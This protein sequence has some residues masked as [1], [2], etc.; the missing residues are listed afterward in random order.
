M[1]E[2]GEASLLLQSFVI[3]VKTQFERDVKIIRSDNELEFL[4][5]SMKQFYTQKGIIHHTSCIDTPQQN[6][7]VERKHRHVLNVAPPLLFQAYLTIDFWG[8]SILTATYVINRTPSKVLGGKTP[9]KVLFKAQ[10]PYDHVKMLGCLCYTHFKSRTRDKFA[11]RS[12]KCVFVGY[13]CGKKGWKVYDLETNEIFVSCDV[14]F[15]KTIFPF[16]IHKVGKNEEELRNANLPDETCLR[17]WSF[18]E[19]ASGEIEL[20][21]G[22]EA[23][24]EHEGASLLGSGPSAPAQT[25]GDAPAGSEGLI[26]LMG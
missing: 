26:S 3:M 21:E 1:R 25:D 4:S 23:T 11:P 8:E 12:R 2:K 14:G 5:G 6:E 17:D 10:P 19:A 24:M 13:P 9:Y 18:H 20:I 22:V 15:H 7:S 16:S